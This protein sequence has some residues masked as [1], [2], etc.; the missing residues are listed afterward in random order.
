MTT[1]QCTNATQPKLNFHIDTFSCVTGSLYVYIDTGSLNSDTAWHWYSNSCGSNQIGLGDTL[2]TSLGISGRD[3]YVRG[4]GICSGTALCGT[5]NVVGLDTVPP[6][7]NVDPLPIITGQCYAGYTY[8]P[9][10]PRATD[11][12]AGSVYGNPSKNPVLYTQGMDSVEWIYTDYWQ[13]N[14]T[15]QKCYIIVDDNIA[16]VP[17]VAVLPV[18]NTQC[19]T[20]LSVFPTSIENCAWPT[21]SGFGPGPLTAYTNSLTYN[22][23][24]I[25][26]IIWIYDD[27][28]GNVTTQNQIVRIQDTIG[29][30][31]ICPNDTIV[32][33]NPN[34]TAATINNISPFAIDACIGG[35][36]F[37]YNL[38]GTSFGSFLGDA[39]GHS[40]NIGS[41]ML[42]YTATDALG[43]FSTCSTHVY[44]YSTIGIENSLE[45]AHIQII[46]QPN[47][48]HFIL[49][50]NEKIGEMMTMK[51]HDERGKL[52]SSES[53][54]NMGQNEFNYSSLSSG[55]YYVSILNSMNKIYALQ[56]FIE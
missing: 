54:K 13:G 41:T 52:V 31:V 46:P 12:C 28:R 40:F 55:I 17:D 43:N 45:S 6:V 25:D 4:E 21:P 10:W 37:H 5:I 32:F 51:I 36:T 49:S 26:T 23:Q 11:N 35:V 22:Q 7:P 18:I 3:F 9:N 15:V 30:E 39:S 8:S 2:K 24:G 20:T 14:V 1:A 47:D 53:F 42:E 27:G 38:I 56:L 29:P 19:D 48:G 50:L 44:V 16:P 33:A 34:Q